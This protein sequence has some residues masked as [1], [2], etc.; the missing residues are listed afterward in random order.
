MG[1]SFALS[2]VASLALSVVY[3]LGGQPQTEGILLFV[4]L[5]GIGLGLILWGKELMPSDAY[6]EER[7]AIPAG[8]EQRHE[9]EVAFE[10]GAGAVERRGFL[11]KLLAAAIAPL[12]LLP[13]FPI[14]SLGSPHGGSLVGTLLG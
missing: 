13:P 3:A 10:S 2:V 4:S 11:A 9:A 5:G 1:L 8:T 6:V 12:R 14:S 7:K